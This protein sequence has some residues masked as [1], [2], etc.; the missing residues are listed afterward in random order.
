MRF[1]IATL[2]CK[3]NQYDSAIIESRLGARGFERCEFAE[4][5]DV[6]IVNTCTVTDK[7]DSESLRMARRAR[8]LNPNARI[9]MTGCL[10]QASPSALE[11]HREIDAIVG[12]GR[13]DDL[14]LEPGEPVEQRRFADIGPADQRDLQVGFVLRRGLLEREPRD[15]FVE[16]LADA[17]PMRRRHEK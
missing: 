8:R 13:L 2:G 17:M 9:V 3:V 4:P 1:A 16:Q 14:A 7:A 10:A 5:A 12:L 11:R 15:D 6:Y